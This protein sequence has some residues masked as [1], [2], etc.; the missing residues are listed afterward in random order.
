MNTL[1]ININKITESLVIFK[2]IGK[3]SCMRFYIV[4]TKVYDKRDDFNCDI[5]NVP[6]LDGDVPRY[7]VNSYSSQF[8]LKS[9]RTHFGQFVLS[10]RSIRTHLI[11]FSQL[12][13]NLVD[14]YSV[15]S[16]RTHTKNM[17]LM[18]Y[19]ILLMIDR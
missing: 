11:K 7:G 1:K 6:F 10:F 12:V 18:L 2:K 15:W 13:L 3:C 8:V 16:I 17:I 19:I 5:V 9:M 4:S 14:S